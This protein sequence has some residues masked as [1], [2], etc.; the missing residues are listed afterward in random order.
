MLNHDNGEGIF[1]IASDPKMTPGLKFWTWGYRDSYPVNARERQF[2][3]L[4][5]G[6]GHQFFSPVSIAANSSR[7]WSETYIPTAGLPGVTDANED[8]LVSLHSDK[9]AYDGKTDASFTLSADVSVAAPGTA[10][11]A[12]V[13]GAADGSRLLLDTLIRPDPKEA[14]HIR[15]TR[16]LAEIGPGQ[17]TLGLKL[18]DA[19]GKAFLSTGTPIS[20]AN[21]V[22]GVHGPR[23]PREAGFSVRP[24]GNGWL[25]EFGTAGTRDVEIADLRGRGLGALRGIR[26]PACIVPGREGMA[27]IRI[28]ENGGRPG[29][30]RILAPAR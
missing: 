27:L 26:G 29:A 24:Y 28:R 18:I 14:A 12:V 6:A 11:R 10:Y 22:L 20:V 5:A 2:I 15:L 16:P 19:Q 25:L 21:S 8:A 3:E 17:Q 9:A 7:D 4:W 13:T 23:A 30:W 1:R